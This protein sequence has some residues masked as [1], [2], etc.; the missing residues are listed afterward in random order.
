MPKTDFIL[1]SAS[2]QRL[3]LLQQIGYVP[4]KIAPADIDETTLKTETPLAYV[5]RMALQKAL[6]TASLFPNENILAG[7]TVVCVGR[8]ILHKAQSDQEQTA[9]MQLLSGRSCRVISAVCLISR[10]GKISQRCVT[11]RVITKKL[12]PQEIKDYVA[13]REWIGCS[14]YKIEGT[15]GGYVKKIIGS[16]SG[17]VGLPLFETQNLLEGIGV[18]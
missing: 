12:S 4:Q 10:S 8:R 9:V 1:A 17:I 2:P 5:K 18:K 14:G 16:Y 13:G 7:D 15:F 6:K 3:A 11:S